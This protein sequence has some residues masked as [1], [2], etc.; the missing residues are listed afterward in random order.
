VSG[1]SC[2]ANAI[3]G[4]ID[5]E[6]QKQGE[7]FITP[8]RLMIYYNERA[9]EGTTDS[10]SGA[11]IRDG[12]LTI[13][14]EGVCPEAEWPYDIGQFTLKP[15]ANCYADAAKY[16]TL[17]YALVLQTLYGLKYQIAHAMPVIFGFTVY[18]SFESGA[19]AQ[20]GIVPMP[21]PGEQV[22]GGHAVDM[23]G[24]DDAKKMVECRNS[25]SSSWG[26]Q[27]HFWMPYAYITDPNLCS[28]FWELRLES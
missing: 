7:P 6:R 18:E 1:N 22:V 20:T 13:S 24:Y 27:G 16:V 10:D 19:V 17:K 21:Q 9:I 14:H 26:D 11:M 12:I 2:T 3:A 15:P 28:D 25:W 5:Y 8:S 23:I 4:A